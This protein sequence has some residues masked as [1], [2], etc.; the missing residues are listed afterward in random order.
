MRNRFGWVFCTVRALLP[1]PVS[2]PDLLLCGSRP[3]GCGDTPACRKTGSTAIP[4]LPSPLSPFPD[5]LLQNDCPSDELGPPFRP[6]LC[7]LLQTHPEPGAPRAGA[8]GKP[9]VSRGCAPRRSDW[10]PWGRGLNSR[11]VTGGLLSLARS[12]DALGLGAECRPGGQ[13]GTS[14]PVTAVQVLSEPPLLC[15]GSSL[16]Q[17]ACKV[18]SRARG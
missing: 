5:T 4:A 2:S 9:Q 3:L 1:Q 17:L 13:A 6:P 15:F 18:T 12:L 14:L 7:P 11:L 8:G 10:V 16:A